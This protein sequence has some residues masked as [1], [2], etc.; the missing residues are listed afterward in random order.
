MDVSLPRQHVRDSG[1]R[2]D[3]GGTLRYA[4]VRA[5]RLFAQAPFVGKI[6]H[7]HICWYRCRN[8]IA[9]S[10]FRCELRTSEVR[11]SRHDLATF[12]QEIVAL[13]R[14][15]YLAAPL[16]SNA[17]VG[18][19]VRIAG[20]RC[21]PFRERCAEAVHGEAVSAIRLKG[22]EHPYWAGDCEGRVTGGAARAG[23]VNARAARPPG[24]NKGPG[25]NCGSGLR[26][27]ISACAPAP[28]LASG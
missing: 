21:N 22:G 25:P 12:R 15:A 23:S 16:M 7:A 3:R 27:T 14:P 1:G 9:S 19:F 2:V 17:A 6:P 24:P 13:I 5:Q 11:P 18:E 8:F 20:F 10:R 4:W 26:P 28:W